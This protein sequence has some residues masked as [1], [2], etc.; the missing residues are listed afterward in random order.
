MAAMKRLNS[1]GYYLV[2][3]NI[4]DYSQTLKVLSIYQTS[5]SPQQKN[6]LIC[7]KLWWKVIIHR[8]VHSVLQ[9]S[10]YRRA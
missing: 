6:N 5:E 2:A 10:G 8:H 1:G 3:I 4:H 9:I 7:S